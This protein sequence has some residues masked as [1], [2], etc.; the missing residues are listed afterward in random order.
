MLTTAQDSCA[1]FIVRY[2]GR[3]ALGVSCVVLTNAIALAGPWI[4]KEAVDDLYVGITDE[5][6]IYYGALLI[7]AAVAGGASR[8]V[9]RRALIGA[10]RGHRI[11]HS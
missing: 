4:L 2:R 3:L 9:T 11:R 5:K 1:A 6:L 7:A 8:F 10:S